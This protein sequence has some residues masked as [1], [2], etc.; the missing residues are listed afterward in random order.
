MTSY[1][2]CAATTPIDPEAYRALLHYVEIEYGNAGSRTHEYGLAASRAVKSAREKVAALSNSKPE[3][4]IFT[5]GATEANNLAILGIQAHG[6]STGKR[7]IVT[8]AIEHKAVLEPVSAL[9]KQGFEATFVAPQNDG[10][11]TAEDVMRAVRP[12][13]LIVSVMHANNET[14]ALQPIDEIAAQLRG[15]SAFLHVDAAQTYGKSNKTLTNTDIDMISVSGH[16]IFAPKDGVFYNAI[17]GDISILNDASGGKIKFSAGQSATAQMTI[18]STGNVLINTTTD[19]GFKLDVNGP[20]RVV[21]TLRLDT[22][23]VPSASAYTNGPLLSFVTAS[24]WASGRRPGISFWG[25]GNSGIYFYYDG[26]LNFRAINDAGQSMTFAST[27]FVTA[28][29]PWT[30][31]GSNI[32]YSTGNVGIGTSSPAQKLDVNG[33]T[34]ITGNLIF[35][36]G[37]RLI[38]YGTSSFFAGRDAAAVYLAYG[39]GAQETHIG[40][41]STGNIRLRTTANVILDQGTSKLLI[42]TTT[43]AGFRLDVNGTARVSGVL[44]IANASSNISGGSSGLALNATYF[45]DFQFA[46]GGRLHRLASNQFGINSFIGNNIAIGY[47]PTGSSPAS[48]KIELGAGTATAGTAPLKLRAGTNLTTPENGAFEYDGTNL[49]F[50]VGGVRKTVV[51]L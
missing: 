22:E 3:E 41:A 42:G 25:Q 13:T 47:D 43:D 49:Y 32:S 29:Q 36:A 33:N 45:T 8:T 20:A 39:F 17:G 38:Q 37:E 26:G 1:F 51:L 27:G 2:D 6:I 24:G 46:S 5:S 30:I 7:H 23:I 28:N 12:D 48:A 31:S 44:T 14:G 34:Q 15:H 50:T 11:V 9:I 40:S 35:P 18:A 21:N 4:V 19:A 10:R 16:K